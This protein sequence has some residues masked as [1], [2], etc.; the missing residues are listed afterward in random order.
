MKTQIKS[1][2]WHEVELNGNL[3]T[4]DTFSCKQF[5]QTKLNGKWDSNK[6]GWVVDLDAVKKYT[7]DAGTIMQK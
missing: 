5:I 4:G 6:K 1:H 7:T 2:G 3:L